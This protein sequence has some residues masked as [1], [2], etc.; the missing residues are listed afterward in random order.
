MG[1][2]KSGKP[3]LRAMTVQMAWLWTNNQKDSRLYQKWAPRFNS[4]RSKKTAIIA[5]SRQLVVAIYHYLVNDIEI[6]GVVY[7]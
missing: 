4:K 5:M 2:S 3:M 7:S 6:E 1:I